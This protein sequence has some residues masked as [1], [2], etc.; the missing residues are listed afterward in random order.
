M[1]AAAITAALGTPLTAGAEPWGRNLEVFGQFS[2]QRV[3]GGFDLLAPV[4]QDGRRLAFLE[5]K[6][7][8]SDRQTQEVNVGLGLRQLLDDS[9]W[10][11]GAFAQY[12]RRATRW[13][14]T[15]DQLTLG[16]EALGPR[17]D[18]RVNHYHPL[19]DAERVAGWVGGIQFS[20]HRTFTQ[21]SYEEALGGWDAEVGVLL[22][23]ERL[24]TRL[25][26]GG[27]TLD[28]DLNDSTNG[29]KARLEVRPT[30]RLSLEV[31]HREDDLLGGETAFTLRYALGYKAE[32]GIRTQ[33]E[34][35]IEPTRRDVDVLVTPPDVTP[36]QP[37]VLAENTLHIDSTR[38]SAAGDGSYERPYRSVADC[39][40]GRC[41]DA[42][43]LVRL[44]RGDSHERDPYRLDAPWR[45]RA[46]QVLWGEGWQ[47]G[48]S[49]SR[50]PVYSGWLARGHASPQE[51][52]WISPP[53]GEAGILLADGSGVSGVA[54]DVRRRE[55]QPGGATPDT[56]PPPAANGQAPA[57]VPDNAGGGSPNIDGAGPTGSGSAGGSG[58]T[59]ATPT[60]PVTPTTPSTPGTPVTPV[61]PVTPGTPVTPPP[62]AALIA[63]GAAGFVV[64]GN[65]LLTDS[66]GIEVRGL[67][68]EVESETITRRPVPD[69]ALTNPWGLPERAP[70][71][72]LILDNLVVVPQ[73]ALDAPGPG[74]AAVALVNRA[75]P[76]ETSRQAL[77]FRDATLADPPPGL[78]LVGGV[79]RAEN[80]AEGPGA[81]AVQEVLIADSELD[82]GGALILDNHASG[83]GSARQDLRLTGGALVGQGAAITLTNQAGSASTASQRLLIDGARGGPFSATLALSNTALDGHATQHL[84]I[85][86]P[87]TLTAATLDNRAEGGNATQGVALTGVAL[88]DGAPA[89]GLAM[90]NRASGGGIAGQALMGDAVLVRLDHLGIAA[91]NQATTL[92]RA[93]QELALA[94]TTGSAS[95]RLDLLNEAR[96]AS[97]I[98]SAAFSGLDFGSPTGQETWIGLVNT[99]I[100]LGQA[101]QRAAIDGARVD[102]PAGGLFAGNGAY[103]GAEALQSLSIT[104]SGGDLAWLSAFNQAAVDGGAD[105]RL[106]V[107]GVGVRAAASGGGIEVSNTA[108]RDSVVRQTLTLDLAGIELPNAGAAVV[109]RAESGSDAIQGL[110]LGVSG[111][112]ELA[113]L[114]LTGSA[115]WESRALQEVSVE[116]PAD[117]ALGALALSNL[118]SGGG[119]IHQTVSLDFARA[120]ARP[121]AARLGELSLTNSAEG[122]AA[123]VQAFTGEAL[124]LLD[125]QGAIALS[126][127]AGSRG[128]AFQSAALHTTDASNPGNTGLV[129]SNSAAD[130]GS[131]AAQGLTLDASADAGS[132]GAMDLDND[133]AAG[134]TALQDLDLTAASVMAGWAWDGPRGISADNGANQGDAAQTLTLRAARLDAWQLAS[135]NAAQ[136][137]GRAIQRTRVSGASG[138]VQGLSARNHASSQGSAEQSATLEGAALD[139]TGS[140]DLSNAASVSASAR[141]DL[142][143]G[144][145]DL[146][147]DFAGTLVLAANSAADA[148]S[149][150][151]DWVIEATG[152]LTAP[153]DGWESRGPALWVR[154]AASNGATARQTGTLAAASVDLGTGGIRADNQ[155]TSGGNAG[156]LT[157]IAAAD[158]AGSAGAGRLTAL[159]RGSGSG[160]QATQG[161]QVSGIALAGGLD[162]EARGEHAARVTQDLTQG[163]AVGG[164]DLRALAAADTLAGAVQS[165]ALDAAGSGTLTDI[166]IEAQATAAGFVEQ[167]AVLANLA[168]ASDTTAAQVRSS[169]AAGAT[170]QVVELEGVNL[171]GAER[172][173]LLDALAEDGGQATQQA[174]LRGSVLTGGAMEILV[175]PNAPTAGYIAQHLALWSTPARIWLEPVT[176]TSMG[177][178]AGITQTLTIDGARQTIWR[179]LVDPEGGEQWVDDEGNPGDGPG[180]GGDGNWSGSTNSAAT[181]HTVPGWGA[182]VIGS[183][184]PANLGDFLSPE[185]AAAI[186]GLNLPSTADL[187][188]GAI[189]YLRDLWG[190]TGRTGL[191]ESGRVTPTTAP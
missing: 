74:A 120:H 173:L 122:G 182:G 8:A 61:T 169:T 108:F 65:L 82:L 13:S 46:G 49:P 68:T 121:A 156:Q 50:N 181:L 14:N 167:S 60:T 54:V 144:I 36:P 75:G 155:A 141:Q 98:Q 118:G 165:I 80:R 38:G 67:A 53:E 134:G 71:Q 41:R 185:A 10:I 89:A 160:S 90:H 25:Y 166:L 7:R 35:M 83:G 162:V 63:D 20:G 171:T 2:D 18:L 101:I 91:T 115:G 147:S 102:L 131:Y 88:G 142:G 164:G 125:D 59:P 37:V 113:R 153:A 106:A 133:A 180:D 103:S 157:A 44:W 56:A 99:G 143:L 159:A 23:I 48:T 128:S 28:G 9:G 43:A 129:A 77:L 70:Y 51:M 79:L 21:E 4:W 40:Q 5:L 191:S 16:L 52:P 138:T 19:S 127:E 126:N 179:R 111:T 15:F 57:P 174:T 149:A 183:S 66:V 86:A 178:L 152:R 6:G 130:S 97:A 145:R 92:G 110:M 114:T 186:D 117:A 34:R 42:G 137:S 161:I 94:A 104:A 47:V 112:T 26:A 69:S 146:A 78:A 124:P 158:A 189:R 12:D 140:A 154:S 132:L 136:S 175:Q 184:R 119:A 33:R 39:L 31:S 139:L 96:G 87:I 17:L 85:A 148:A 168:A 150:V 163:G 72:G 64:Q 135:S 73:G 95:A 3:L 172:A 176:I 188:P 24:E 170:N 123:A 11:L 29:W 81:V 100:G 76:A 177:D 1:L 107:A 27:Y 187:T 93:N 84:A 116:L 151:Q 62:P 105:Q 190:R 32:R 58:H 22:P 45:L 109:T 55:S 30:K